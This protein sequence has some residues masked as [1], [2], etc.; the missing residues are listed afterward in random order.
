VRPL[1]ICVCSDRI[2]AN[3]QGDQW[4]VE[5]ACKQFAAEGNSEYYLPCGEALGRTCWKEILGYRGYC[6]IVISGC[7]V[8]PSNDIGVHQFEEKPTESCASFLKA[9]S[10]GVPIILIMCKS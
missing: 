5:K 10:S 2:E 8:A 4:L 3:A 1:L 9:L 6:L 7:R